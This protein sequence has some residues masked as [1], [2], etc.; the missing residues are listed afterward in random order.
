MKTNLRHYQ[1]R[2]LSSNGRFGVAIQSNCEDHDGGWV[3]IYD[4]ND[5]SLGSHFMEGT[6][7]SPLIV[8]AGHVP[9]GC[10]YKIQNNPN[11]QLILNQNKSAL[12]PCSRERQCICKEVITG[13]IT[14]SPS[15]SLSPPQSTTTAKSGPS[16][17][18][19]T[20]PA[21]AP[22]LPTAITTSS[23]VL[24][25]N[26]ND[27][28]K[29]TV[30]NTS[31]IEENE[32]VN[33]LLT[34]MLILFIFILIGLIIMFILIRNS[35]NRINCAQNSSRVIDVRSMAVATLPSRRSSAVVQIPTPI[36]TSTNVRSN[37]QT[38]A[39]TIISEVPEVPEVLEVP[40]VPR[41][42][43]LASD[44]LKRKISSIKQLQG[45]KVIKY[46]LDEIRT[47]VIN[48]AKIISTNN[49]EESR[50]LL[51]ETLTWI[52]NTYG[53]SPNTFDPERTRLW[54]AFRRILS[55]VERKDTED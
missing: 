19:P 28:Y 38:F 12:G 2:K 49:L 30:T 37:E 41:I 44:T 31:S 33:M 11:E 1:I 54:L 53:Q 16:V 51:G 32:N 18:K 39:S 22:A 50:T 6:D 21:P 43:A 5:C 25:Q 20:K 17:T 9:R 3:T 42:Q 24:P 7:T 34:L 55:A 40:E 52:H 47:I 45:C 29:P 14:Q 26:K 15:P 46:T 13:I 35:N 27:L 10:Y 8:T 4:S 23:N 48:N 36:A